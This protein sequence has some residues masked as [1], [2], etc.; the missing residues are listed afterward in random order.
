VVVVTTGVL[1]ANRVM[2]RQRKPVQPQDEPVRPRP[3]WTDAPATAA[4]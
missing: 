3:A 1:V 4:D 2:L